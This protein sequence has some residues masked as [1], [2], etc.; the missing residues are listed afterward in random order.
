MIKIIIK[1][2]DKHK[3]DYIYMNATGLQIQIFNLF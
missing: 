2:N 1:K 3:N